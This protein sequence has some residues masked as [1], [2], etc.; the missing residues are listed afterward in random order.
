MRLL[1][2]LLLLIGCPSPG[3][4]GGDDDDS[5]PADDDDA[6]IENP[7]TD[8]VVDPDVFSTPVDLESVVQHHLNEVPPD[9]LIVVLEDGDI[10]PILDALGGTLLGQ[11]PA[12]NAY[13]VA[14]P[15]A[16][17]PELEAAQALAASLPGVSGA[18]WNSIQE[19]H[20][21]PGYCLLEDDNH[22]NLTGPERC[23]YSDIGYYQAARILKKL[24]EHMTLSPVKVA[25]VDSGLQKDFGAFDDVYVLNLADPNREPIDNHGHGTRVSGIIAADDGDGSTNGIASQVL[26]ARVALEVGGFS[27]DTFATITAVYRAVLDGH[28]DVVNMS[29]GARYTPAEAAMQATVMEL[30]AELTDMAPGTVFV[31]SA[32]NRNEE[33]TPTGQTPG[34]LDAPNFLTVGGTTHC[35]PMSRWIHSDP[36]YGTSWGSLVDLS[37]PAQTVPVLPYDPLH[38]IY[39]PGG[40]PIFKDGTSYSSPMVAATAAI[41]KSFDSTLSGADIKTYLTDYALITDPAIN[42]RR[43]VMML[44]IEQML[45]DRGAPYEVLDLI[46]ADDQPGQWDVPFLALNRICEGADL[47]VQGQGAWTFFPD[48]STGAGFINDMGLGFML[49]TDDGDVAFGLSQ[50]GGTFAL[51]TEYVI[52]G[53]MEASFSIISRELFT[54]GGGG[55]V[56]FDECA[57]TERNPLDN[58]PMVVQ[59]SARSQGGLQGYQGSVM[60]GHEFDARF[61][62]PMIVY[63]GAAVIPVLETDC[64]GGIQ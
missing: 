54:S 62:V 19:W 44:P 12:L 24:A 7:F 55:V 40:D 46:D 56:Q 5:A 63:P 25:V 58:S 27:P 61:N 57:I 59:V 64:E 17:L 8:Y 53:Q 28:A 6:T 34:G 18:S 21:S 50:V 48:A 22:Q 42:W 11:I 23:G 2:L 35:D 38:A 43:H 39:N 41:M 47:S 30:Y 31:T 36:V 26:G 4:G 3:G 60:V 16:T 20:S 45:I 37:A 29:Y 10:Q 52:P 9:E 13:Q 33:L 49:G 15:T 51:G 14:L 32:G 1:L